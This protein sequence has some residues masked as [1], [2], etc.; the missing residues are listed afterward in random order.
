MFKKNKVAMSVVTGILGV[1]G[2]ISSA[3]AVHVNPDGTGQVL[4]FPYFNANDGYVTNVNL[5]NSTDQT[6]AVKIRFREGRNSN[7]VLDFNIYMSPEDIWTGSIKPTKDSSGNLVGT[8]STG[9]RT[10]TLPALAS[11]EDGKCVAEQAFTGQNVYKDV[12]AADTREGYIEVI[13]MGVVED[14]TVKAGVLH[15]NG[16]PSNCKAVED[17]W[18][19]KTFTQGVGAA[20]KGLSAPTGGL[21]GSSA[22][23]NI[24]RGSA[25]AVDPVA[26]DNYSTQAQHYLSDDADNFLLPSLASGNVTSSS[27]MT[28]NSAGESEMVVTEWNKQTDACLALGDSLLPACG[29]NPYPMAHALLAPHLMNEYF[30]D[31]TDGYDGHT[32]WVVTL[33]M[34]KHG[35]NQATKDVVAN[36]EN[37][38]FDRE[39]SRASWAAKT[40]FGFSPVLTGKK[41]DS[42]LLGREVNVVS[43]KTT[44]PSFDNTCDVLSSEARQL[45]STGAFVSGWARLSFP[46]YSLSSGFKS[47]IGYGLNPSTYTAASNVYKGVP[48]IGA[49]F[50]EGNVSNNPSARFGDALPHK[51]QRD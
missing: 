28:K 29:T 30:L 38:I 42:S 23:I 6:K 51:I 27:V 4:L 44:D 33:P 26:I 35:I 22:I 18:N 40:E 32:D 17:A 13:E 37:G 14:P 39:E 8:L 49:A 15:S 47:A 16:K 45:V 5:V 12:T 11:C 34:K 43:F 48:A 41:A 7:D 46:G 2:V 1:V 20:A 3:Q 21:F 31:P 36:F 10:C 19:K 25:F 24:K 9:D 50:I